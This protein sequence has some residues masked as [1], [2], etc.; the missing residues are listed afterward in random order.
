[1]VDFEL[2][3]SHLLDAGAEPF[4]LVS[5][6]ALATAD[7]LRDRFGGQL[8]VLMSPEHGFFGAA[9]AGEKTADERHPD[10]GI[11]VYSLYGETR[12]PTPAM[13]EG[14]GRI[15][16]DLQDLGVRCYTYL[17][18]LK[19]VLEA[20]AEAGL[21]VTVVDRPLPLGGMIDGPMRPNP[22][23]ASFVAPLNVPLCHGMTPGEAATWI[24]RAEGLDVDLTV[25]PMAQ[26]SHRCRGPWPDFVPPSPAIRSWDTAVMYPATVFSEAYPALDCDRAG[27]LAFRVLGAPW[28]K[29]T[30]LAEEL[31]GPLSVCGMG[32]R[33]YRYSPASGPYAGRRL[34]GVLLSCEKPDAF[35]PVTG[36]VLAL[37][38]IRT[39]HAEELARDARPE[40]FDK[41]YGGAETRNAIEAGAFSALFESWIAG[42]DEY[43]R[44]RVSLY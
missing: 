31:R 32:V 37:A 24:V 1:M 6:Q 5:H 33:P 40:W 22:A 3:A 8:A 15:V 17:G 11:P 42:Q 9:A 7:R 26:W 14:L 25:I 27:A 35:Y 10:W 18:T 20:A 19:L 13:L 21:P 44:Q 34:E 36:G 16:F 2:L 38:A 28:M 29:G 4:G 43:L 41:L 30:E 23:F 39:H 12:R